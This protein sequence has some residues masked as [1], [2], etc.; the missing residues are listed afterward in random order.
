MR[1]F[2]AIASPFAMCSTALAGDTPPLNLH[3]AVD[4]DAGRALLERFEEAAQESDA[5]YND[6]GKTEFLIIEDNRVARLLKERDFDYARGWAQGV[7]SM[8]LPH[9]MEGNWEIVCGLRAHIAFTPVLVS[10][11]TEGDEIARD[12]GTLMT[13]AGLQLGP[14]IT[15]DVSYESA[16]WIEVALDA[17]AEQSNGLGF[18]FLYREHASQSDVLRDLR[19]GA[20]DYGVFTS[21]YLR[22]DKFNRLLY[23]G[24]EGGA[25]PHTPGLKDKSFRFAST[26]AAPLRFAALAVAHDATPEMRAVAEQACA[27]FPVQRASKQEI[28]AEIVTLAKYT[29]LAMRAE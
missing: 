14:T 11:G 26:A 7:Q 12:W 15:I 23:L 4:T 27:S 20:A 10:F 25:D 22:S 13:Q 1:L 18:S 29:L 9:T 19:S 16:S 24:P 3:G 2:L 28:E 8:P 6:G 21:G 5:I 17:A